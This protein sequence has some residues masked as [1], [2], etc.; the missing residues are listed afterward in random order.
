MGVDTRPMQDGLGKKTANGSFFALKSSFEGT[1]CFHLMKT[2]VLCSGSSLC[3]RLE[4]CKWFA[5][6]LITRVLLSSYEIK[7]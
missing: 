1:W 6:I 2:N 7:E 5:A 4:L 3:D